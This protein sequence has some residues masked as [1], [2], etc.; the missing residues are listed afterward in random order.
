MAG[1]CE[2]G[3]EPS[4]SL[5]AICAPLE[6]FADA[7]VKQNVF[8]CTLAEKIEHHWIRTMEKI[9]DFIGNQTRDL[10]T[11]QRQRY[12]LTAAQLRLNRGVVMKIIKM[13]RTLT[14]RK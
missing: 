8:R 9:H 5:K 10:M 2:G 12:A 13:A 4:G 7:E 14:W 3:N 1:L 11:S 6:Q